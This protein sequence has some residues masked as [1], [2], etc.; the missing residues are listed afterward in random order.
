M[1]KFVTAH[2]LEL[3]KCHHVTAFSLGFKHIWG[4]YKSDIVLPGWLAG[5]KPASRLRS[6]LNFCS[7]FK[8]R[9]DDII[10]LLLLW[11]QH[12][13]VVNFLLCLSA[14]L[15]KWMMRC[16]FWHRAVSN[17]CCLGCVLRE[18]EEACVQIKQGMFTGEVARAWNLHFSYPG[19]TSSRRQEFH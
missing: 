4:I 12:Y 10:P 2:T 9:P 6:N 11:L 14:Y 7:S 1:P 5:P 13:P 3:P 18:Q 17:Y 19:W 15:S 8:V 16:S